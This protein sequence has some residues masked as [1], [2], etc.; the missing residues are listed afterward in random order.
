MSRWF[1]QPHLLVV[2]RNDFV[3]K[4]RLPRTQ[5]NKKYSVTKIN[6]KLKLEALNV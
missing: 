6:S 2:A 1:K 5:S 3:T 4:H